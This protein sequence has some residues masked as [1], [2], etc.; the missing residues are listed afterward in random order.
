MAIRFPFSGRKRSDSI[1]RVA[2]DL[3]PRE[4]GWLPP[5]LRR[6]ISAI[7]RYVD[8]VG[9]SDEFRG[10]DYYE[11][12]RLG[13]PVGPERREADKKDAADKAE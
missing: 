5:R 1:E 4:Q 8:R 11:Y 3:M 6:A 9:R 10:N 13:D 7:D 12:G 2:G